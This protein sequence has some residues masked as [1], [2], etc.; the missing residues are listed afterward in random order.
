MG[1]N[2]NCC[3]AAL[4]PGTLDLLSREG[5][6]VEAGAGAGAGVVVAGGGTVAGMLTDGFG[7]G[8]AGIVTG[9]FDG[10]GAGEKSAGLLVFVTIS[11]G[12]VTAGAGMVDGLASGGAAGGGVTA[13]SGTSTLLVGGGAGNGSDGVS[14]MDGDSWVWGTGCST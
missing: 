12:V 13:G 3:A 14:G 8:L 7:D 11:G 5:I 10:G 2:P 1:L 6:G 4:T 9:G